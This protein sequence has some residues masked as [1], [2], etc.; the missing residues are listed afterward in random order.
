MTNLDIIW[1]SKDIIL[2]TK[3]HIVKAM[4]CSHVRMWK[5]DHKEG[6]APENWCFWIVVLEKTLESPLDSKEIKPVNLKGNHPWI[7]IGR[8]DAE[9]LVLWPP[10][11][12]NWLIG[13][14]P[15]SGKD[16]RQKEKSVAKGS[17]CTG[18]VSGLGKSSGGRNGTTLQYSCQ[19]NPIDRRVWRATVHRVANSRT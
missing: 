1:K 3:V 2:L 16:W 12:K 17:T 6:W 15:D 18:S 5:V 14:D 19:E 8:T 10:D 7:Y 4:T 9:A 11:V 13:K